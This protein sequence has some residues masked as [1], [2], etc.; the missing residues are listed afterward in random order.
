MRI[1]ANAVLPLLVVCAG[2]KGL[3]AE[4]LSEAM[5]PYSQLEELST[6]NAVS[7][8]SNL[9]FFLSSDFHHGGVASE[10]RAHERIL[11]GVG[12]RP[13]RAIG[14]NLI[15]VKY[16]ALPFSQSFDFKLFDSDGREVEKTKAG[17]ANSEPA[18]SPQNVTELNSLKLQIIRQESVK[19]REL[20]RPDEMFA[21]TNKGTYELV[22][23][24]RICVP[25]TN[26]L[27]DIRAMVF[28]PG[29]NPR[30]NGNYH[31]VVSSPLRVKVVKD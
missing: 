24:R 22:I 6:T 18:R 14:T 9:V 1:I 12:V 29:Q 26:G 16:F 28:S 5:E 4:P 7:I 31:V 20:F 13:L 23:R 2:A 17:L 10:F 27:P 25:I 3:F 30:H 19:V 15:H 21:M 8:T 11:H